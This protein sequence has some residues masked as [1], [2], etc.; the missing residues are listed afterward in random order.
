MTGYRLLLQLVQPSRFSSILGLMCRFRLVT[1]A[2]W[3]AGSVIVPL[4]VSWPIYADP[5]HDKQSPY[6]LTSRPQSKPWLLMPSEATGPMPKLLSQTGAFKDV[7]TLNPAES[8]I[9]YDLN[10]SFWSD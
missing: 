5:Q 1:R 3:C 9:P 7:R 6:G 2:I 4:L 8:L 10:V